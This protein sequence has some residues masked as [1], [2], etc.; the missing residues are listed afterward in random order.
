MEL[1]KHVALPIRQVA[2]RRTL[3]GFKED[4]GHLTEDVVLLAG[5][6]HLHRKPV[7]IQEQ[8]LSPPLL[9]D[10]VWHWGHRVVSASQLLRTETI[11][12][13]LCYNK[14]AQLTKC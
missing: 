12:P 7:S 11:F 8:F 6:I 3:R 10:Y 2:P 4:F 1:A 13:A 14:Y 5:E 9:T